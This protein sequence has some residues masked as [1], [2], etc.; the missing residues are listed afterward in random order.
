MLSINNA[1]CIGSVQEWS[2]ER[3]EEEEE[4]EDEAL[5]GGGVGGG[6]GQTETAG[7]NPSTHTSVHHTAPLNTTHNHRQ[8]HLFSSL[9]LSITCSL[10]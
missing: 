4:E 10:A 9:P 6:G 5:G 8:A 3:R 7:V 1:V 2:A